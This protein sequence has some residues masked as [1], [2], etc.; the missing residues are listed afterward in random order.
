MRLGLVDEYQLDIHPVILGSGMPM[1]P[2]LENPI[3]LRLVEIR[4]FGS[5][6]VLLCYRAAAEGQEALRPEQESGA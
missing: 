2:A 4:T 6:V 3:A 5:G 1:F